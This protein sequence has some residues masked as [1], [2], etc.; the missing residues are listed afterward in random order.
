MSQICNYL[1]EDKK[2]I[3]LADLS[4][5]F[6]VDEGTGCILNPKKMRVY[7]EKV[8]SNIF[9]TAEYALKEL[10]NQD[11]FKFLRFNEEK[12]F[13]RKITKKMSGNGISS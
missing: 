10:D 7:C 12:E 3:S 9:H 8:R 2:C 5:A 13:I 4:K 11:Q 6:T 1:T